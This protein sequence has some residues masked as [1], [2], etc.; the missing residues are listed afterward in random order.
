MIPS[1]EVK[2]SNQEFHELDESGRRQIGKCPIR[3]IRLIR[4]PCFA[5]LLGQKVLPQMAQISADEFALES[6]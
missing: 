3:V 2:G 1:R 4:G 6:V 5:W